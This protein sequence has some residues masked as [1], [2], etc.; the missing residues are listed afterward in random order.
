MYKLLPDPCERVKGLVTGT[1]A[2]QSSFSCR[3]STR[4][5]QQDSVHADMITP[6]ARKVYD[7]TY[8]RLFCWRRHLSLCEGRLRLRAPSL[9][10]VC[11]SR[12]REVW[13]R[14]RNGRYGETE[15]PTKTGDV[16]S[17]AADSEAADPPANA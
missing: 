13:L 1:G 7:V 2:D 14:T 11:T 3:E 5:Y 9:N 8:D 12:V 10:V 15:Q 17:E 4:V 16:R 6:C